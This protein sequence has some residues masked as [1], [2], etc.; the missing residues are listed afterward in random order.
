MMKSGAFY[1]KTAWRRPL[2]SKALIAEDFR[3]YWIIPA[4]AAAIYFL[5]S[6][7]P[8]LIS[9]DTLERD[10]IDFIRPLVQGGNAALFFCNTLLPVMTATVLYRYMHSSASASV[11]HAMP[12]TRSTLFNSHFAAGI[13]MSAIPVFFCGSILLLISKPV[14]VESMNFDSDITRSMF[15]WMEWEGSVQ[16]TE[17]TDV[18]SRSAILAWMG[19]SLLAIAVIYAVA[20]FAT[21]VTGNSVMHFILAGV[22]TILAQ[23]ILFAATAYF[24]RFLYGYTMPETYADWL[25][26]INPLTQGYAGYEP[27]LSAGW[28]LWYLISIAAMYG[29]GLYLYLTKKLERAAESITCRPFAVYLSYIASFFGMTVFGSYFYLASDANDFVMYLG[30]AAGFILVFLIAEIILSGTWKIFNK[31]MFVRM[32]GYVLTAVL[33]LASLCFDFTGY[34]T[35]IPAGAGQVQS[36]AL[37]NGFYGKIMGGYSYNAR[38]LELRTAANIEAALHLHQELIKLGAKRS[39]GYGAANSESYGF[40]Y[41]LK[42]GS[43]LSREYRD[44]PIM[45]FLI[46]NKDLKTIMESEEFKRSIVWNH[47]IPKG[48]GEDPWQPSIQ[49]VILDAE[50][51]S[52][53]SF[54]AEAQIKGFYQSF[55][56]DLMDRSYEEMLFPRAPFINLRF[57]MG[58][59]VDTSQGNGRIKTQSGYAAFEEQDMQSDYQYFQLDANF[60]HTTAWLK[61]NGYTANLCLKPEQ[62]HYITVDQ[63]V[64]DKDGYP[65][66]TGDPQRDERIAY[67]KAWNEGSDPGTDSIIQTEE[68]NRFSISPPAATKRKMV[69]TDK[70]Q[71]R[72]V[73]ESYNVSDGPASGIDAYTVAIFYSP[74]E[75]GAASDVYESFDGEKRDSQDTSDGVRRILGSYYELTV[76]AEIAAY[77]E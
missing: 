21:S 49:T 5:L 65:A 40:S 50:G 20:A 27:L 23:G 11:V 7:F 26:G 55:Q 66:Y 37:N 73:L 64:F 74:A 46:E 69:I 57:V 54:S 67:E 15:G 62:V 38:A 2:I 60:H 51:G 53:V 10:R 70:E 3:R 48:S 75:G 33:F 61:A 71:I 16:T 56:K 4:V 76:P 39:K 36:V 58:V 22:L 72:K 45:E 59:P 32:S 47:L 28:T 35:R 8:I 68:E 24:R 52:Q 14:M 63:F 25:I 30:F 19:Y 6:V 29:A 13:C 41:T 77:F 43:D 18:F 9:Y 12:F 34:E 44:L 1:F 17:L 42:N 31:K